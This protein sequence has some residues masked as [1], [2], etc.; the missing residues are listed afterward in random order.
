MTIRQCQHLFLF[1]KANPVF[2]IRNRWIT[3]R[4]KPVYCYFINTGLHQITTITRII[5][6]DRIFSVRYFY[7]CCNTFRK[8][9]SI[10]FSFLCKAVIV[11]DLLSAHRT[12]FISAKGR[13]LWK[14]SRAIL[15]CSQSFSRL[16]QSSQLR[17]E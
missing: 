7:V 6:I 17:S 8:V 9:N 16:R 11:S 5:P 14:K 10:Y 12:F 2:P 3:G 1:Y 13:Y 15:V 4:N